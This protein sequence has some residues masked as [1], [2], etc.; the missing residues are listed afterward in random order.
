MENRKQ[1]TEDR[2]E[3]DWDIRS[4]GSRTSGGQNIR[5]LVNWRIRD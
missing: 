3:G 2:K 1:E 4:S 5:R